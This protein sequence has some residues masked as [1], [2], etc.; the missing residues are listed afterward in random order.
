MAAIY[1]TAAHRQPS[2]SRYR[3]TS[4]C[5][6]FKTNYFQ[7]LHSGFS[8]GRKLQL[9]GLPPAGCSNQFRRGITHTTCFD[10]RST[11]LL[12]SKFIYFLDTLIQ[13]IYF[14]IIKINNFRADL[15]GVS[16]KKEALVKQRNNDH[17]LDQGA[18]PQ[19]NLIS[20][21]YYKLFPLCLFCHTASFNTLY[22]IGARQMS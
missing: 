5:L 21:N 8:A 18:K 4:D 22:R 11:V 1:H 19:N 15:S 10:V 13:Y 14:K 20:R 9:G 17:F 12:F 6:F 7:V 2:R 3:L 16:A